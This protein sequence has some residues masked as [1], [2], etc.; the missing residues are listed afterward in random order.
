MRTTE[1]PKM[2]RLEE[3]LCA[4]VKATDEALAQHDGSVTKSDAMDMSYSLLRAYHNCNPKGV[5][6]P[7]LD[8]ALELLVQHRDMPAAST[9]RK[10]KKLIK[11][12]S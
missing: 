3:N 9:R 7:L 6:T 4:A 10:F 2:N 12:A 5:D 1:Q 8:M 11:R